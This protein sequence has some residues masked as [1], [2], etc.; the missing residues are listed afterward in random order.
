[1]I[2]LSLIMARGGACTKP[3][4][5][6]FFFL[7]F[8]ETARKLSPASESARKKE[9]KSSLATISQVPF[10]GTNELSLK[11]TGEVLKFLK[12]CWV[13][14]RGWGKVGYKVMSGKQEVLMLREKRKPLEELFS[15]LFSSSFLC[16]PHPPPHRGEGGSLPQLFIVCLVLASDLSRG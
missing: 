1:M 4:A 15:F 16:F 3:P 5:A 14:K 7:F 13:G 6:L 8:Q 9:L 12:K 2:F 10:G 11:K